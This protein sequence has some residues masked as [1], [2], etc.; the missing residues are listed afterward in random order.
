MKAGI[1]FTGSGPILILTSYDSLIHPKLIQKLEAKGIRKFLAFEA[2][3]PLVKEKY[4]GHYHVVL[5]DLHQEDDLRIMDYDGHR[6]LM[7]FSL[8]DLGAPL[9]HEP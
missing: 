1:Y 7:N 5:G 8:K 4:G 9:Y 2:P 3:V 6:V